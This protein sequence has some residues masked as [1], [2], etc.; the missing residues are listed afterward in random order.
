MKVFTAAALATCMAGGATAGTLVVDFAGTSATIEDRTTGDPVFSETRPYSGSFRFDVDGLTEPDFIYSASFDREDFEFPVEP[1]VNPQ[2]ATLLSR[3]EEDF[4]TF[5]IG[6]YDIDVSATDVSVS[7]SFLGDD[8]ILD[9]FE[10]GATE[11]INAGQFY[12]DSEGV[13][14]ATYTPDGPNDGTAFEVVPAP[15]PLPATAPLLL[16]GIGVAGMVA[17]RKRTA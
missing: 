8:I 2:G 14:T 13:W 6:R 7:A 17:R 16:V 9:L 10:F 12:I 4:N 3:P 11:D 1:S 5:F 15:V